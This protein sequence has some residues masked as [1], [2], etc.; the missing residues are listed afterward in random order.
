VA[1]SNDP[2]DRRRVL[3]DITPDAQR[4]LDECL[5]R[6]QQTADLLFAQLDDAQQR[7]LLDALDAVRQAA[8]D[9]PADL[10]DPNP[11]RRPARLT[12]QDPPA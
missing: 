11:R 5:P 3:V 8:T 7:V 10:P 2:R 4:V 1:R 6:I 9:L 12:R